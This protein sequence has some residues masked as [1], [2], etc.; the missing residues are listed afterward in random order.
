MTKPIGLL[1]PYLLI[2]KK[3]I[4]EVVFRICLK[5]I[6]NFI[7]LIGKISENNQSQKY[8]TTRKIFT[9]KLLIQNYI[10][11]TSRRM[12]CLSLNY[13]YWRE[14]EITDLPPTKRKKS[15]KTLFKKTTLKMQKQKEQLQSEVKLSVTGKYPEFTK[16]IQLKSKV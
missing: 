2:S 6:E 16:T 3:E 9:Q 4:L 12:Y 13:L 5:I 8:G 11:H 1:G 15:S 14:G 10:T 7:S